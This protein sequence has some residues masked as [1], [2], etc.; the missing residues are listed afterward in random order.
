MKA[1]HVRSTGLCSTM[2]GLPGWTPHQTEWFLWQRKSQTWENKAVFQWPGFHSKGYVP[3]GIPGQW[4]VGHGL[5][6]ILRQLTTICCRKQPEKPPVTEW[7]IWFIKKESKQLDEVRYSSEGLKYRKWMD[8]SAVT[9]QTHP[10]W[11]RL[12]RNQD[13]PLY[14][15]TDRDCGGVVVLS[16]KGQRM[17]RNQHTINWVK[18][19][20]LVFLGV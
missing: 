2:W 4:L 7:S 8:S 19:F 12:G 6:L 15:H 10:W 16:L 1:T 5:P 18:G 13:S 14:E 3:F 11:V 20:L 17:G 9:K